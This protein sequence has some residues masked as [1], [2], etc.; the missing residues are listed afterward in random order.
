MINISKTKADVDSSSSSTMPT[1]YRTLYVTFSQIARK[2]DN[3]RIPPKRKCAPASNWHLSIVR[4][5][6]SRT[7]LRPRDT[8]SSMKKDKAFLP[9]SKMATKMTFRLNVNTGE[10]MGPYQQTRKQWT[11]YFYRGRW[12]SDS[13]LNIPWIRG[14][15]DEKEM[16]SS[17]PNWR[18]SQWSRNPQDWTN[19]T[20]W[21]AGRWYS[22]SNTSPTCIQW[23]HTPGTCRDRTVKV[24][25]SKGSQAQNKSM[26]T[27]TLG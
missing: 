11:L 14:Q 24:T 7:T 27:V 18:P 17:H 3:P 21:E 13:M 22:Y 6:D 4:P 8:T 25:L 12:D 19:S 5:R 1:A 20:G 15:T 9:A 16:N 10:A 26:L 23:L 2:S